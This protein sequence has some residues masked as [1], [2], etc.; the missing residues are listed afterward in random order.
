MRVLKHVFCGV[1]SSLPSV[2][3]EQLLPVTET[4]CFKMLLGCAQCFVPTC[5]TCSLA[6][7]RAVEL[8]LLWPF[9]NNLFE[10]VD[11][12]G[13][14]RECKQLQTGGNEKRFIGFI[15]RNHLISHV[16]TLLKASSWSGRTSVSSKRLKR[17]ACTC[18]SWIYSK[19]WN[20]NSPSVNSGRVF[21]S[22]CSSL[23]WIL[24]RNS[25]R[26]ITQSPVAIFQS[27]IEHNSD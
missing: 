23:T 20:P 8:K 17:T 19:I 6:S 3:R 16:P 21:L 15:S 2:T 27:T 14:V 11:C 24:I 22:C 25:G 9:S 26:A 7:G 12:Q 5:K 18:T 4:P 13:L 1:L 10:L